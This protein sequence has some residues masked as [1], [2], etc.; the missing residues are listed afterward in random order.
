MYNFVLLFVTS[1]MLRKRG[2]F[3]AKLVKNHDMGSSPNLHKCVRLLLVMRYIHPISTV[4]HEL[5]SVFSDGRAGKSSRLLLRTCVKHRMYT[6]HYYAFQV[7]H[8][9]LY[10]VPKL[11][12]KL[13]NAGVWVKLLRFV[14]TVL[15]ALLN[16]APC[17]ACADGRQSS[18]SAPMGIGKSPSADQGSRRMLN[19]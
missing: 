13:I 2:V 17:T 9:A 12:K 11:V 16:F 19:S 6:L 4:Q 14:D 3:F 1:Y 8:A 15:G 7:Y 10:S 5:F 18:P